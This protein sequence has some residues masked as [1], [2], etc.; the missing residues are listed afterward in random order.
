MDFPV[1]HFEMVLLEKPSFEAN[2]SY[3]RFFPSFFVIK[4]FLSMI[5]SFSLPPLNY[6]YNRRLPF[7]MSEAIPYWENLS[8]ILV[9][10]VFFI[11]LFQASVLAV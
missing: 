10:L 11:Y 8:G 5:G 2:C 9:L 6:Q 7:F 1:S 3:V 4:I